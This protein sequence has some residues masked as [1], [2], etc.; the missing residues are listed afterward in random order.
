MKFHWVD[1]LC[2]IWGIASGV[3][4]FLW[5]FWRYS[6]WVATSVAPENFDPTEDFR[7]TMILLLHVAPFLILYV[8]GTAEKIFFG[9]NAT[10]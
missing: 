7:H 9:W 6:W 2:M 1:T 3:S 5:V 4:I 10:K 8:R